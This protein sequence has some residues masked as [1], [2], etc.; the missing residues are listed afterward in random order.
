MGVP[1]ELVLFGG[2]GVHLGA[3]LDVGGPP[4]LTNLLI[5]S[6]S[7]IAEK[8]FQ[9]GEFEAEQFNEEQMDSDC[10]YWRLRDVSPVPQ[11]HGSLSLFRP[12]ARWRIG[13]LFDGGPI[14]HM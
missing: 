1:L 13:Q 12:P 4:L 14:S 5:R 9:N 8:E 10:I 2:V 11:Q 3:V 6:V 7:F